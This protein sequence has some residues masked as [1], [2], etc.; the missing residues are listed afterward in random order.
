[1]YDLYLIVCVV[2]DI[3]GY[4]NNAGNMRVFGHN[5]VWHLIVTAR[6]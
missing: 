4:K 1:M 5:A 3:I 2:L 6:L